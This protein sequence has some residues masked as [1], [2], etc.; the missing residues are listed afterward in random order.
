MLVFQLTFF[1]PIYFC[2][3]FFNGKLEDKIFSY[4]N[5]SVIFFQMM[6]FHLSRTCTFT[7]SLL[8]S[9]LG[10]SADSYYFAQYIIRRIIYRYSW[11]MCT[12]LCSLKS[13]VLNSPKNTCER[14]ILF[15][16]SL[17]HLAS[18]IRNVTNLTCLTL[19]KLYKLCIINLLLSPSLSLYFRRHQ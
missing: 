2:F 17:F 12:V 7:N 9:Y 13:V 4:L 6:F 5:K 3:L 11:P 15:S 18:I 10:R 1:F 19:Y 16:F 14:Y 8:C